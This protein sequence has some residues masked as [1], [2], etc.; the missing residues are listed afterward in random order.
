MLNKQEFQLHLYEWAW[1]RN[2]SLLY[3]WFI[4]TFNSF[5]IWLSLKQFAIQDTSSIDLFSSR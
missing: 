4:I 3:C 1:L 5:T 2:I